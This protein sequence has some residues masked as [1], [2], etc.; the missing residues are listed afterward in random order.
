MKTSSAR[1][2][3]DSPRSKGRPETVSSAG[4]GAANFIFRWNREGVVI[5]INTVGETAPVIT[6][7]T[8]RSGCS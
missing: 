3:R 8:C 2:R 7:V 4:T 6:E 1:I 5:D